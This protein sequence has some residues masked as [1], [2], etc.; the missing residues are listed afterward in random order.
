MEYT[1]I[2]ESSLKRLSMKCPSGNHYTIDV[3]LSELSN[4]FIYKG[5]LGHKVNHSFHPNSIYTLIDSP[6]HGLV[7]AVKTLTDVCAGEELFVN[8]GYKIDSLGQPKWYRD[9]YYKVLQQESN[10]DA[11]K[12]LKNV[13]EQINYLDSQDYK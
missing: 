2:L 7:Q 10:T 5:S 9:L 1:T 4:G 6:R 13:E 3:P 8:Y 11:M 12:I